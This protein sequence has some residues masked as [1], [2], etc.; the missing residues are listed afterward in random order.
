MIGERIKKL[1]KEKGYSL[2]V[3]AEQAGVSKSYLSYLER[4]VK[5]NPSLQFLSKIATTLETSI[6]YL[7][8]EEKIVKENELSDELDKEWVVLLKNAI[9]DG[10]SK[11]DLEKYRDYIRF[12]N[13]K[14]TNK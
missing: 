7:L 9:D 11:D 2:S 14:S 3:L 1:R 6:E 5:N 8:G 13:W 12:V 4:N 10:M